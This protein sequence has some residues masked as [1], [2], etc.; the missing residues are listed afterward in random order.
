MALSP[1]QLE[2]FN[3][4]GFVKIPNAIPPALLKKLQ[5]LFEQ[6]MN[7]WEE[8]TTSRIERNGKAYITNLELLCKKGNLAA[9]ELLG[10]PFLLEM[11]EQICGTDFFMI[12]EF[13]VIKQAGDELHVYWHQDMLHEGKGRC[14][15]IGFYLDP[16]EAGDG[17]LQVVPG[18]HRAGKPICE[19]KE[20]PAIELPMMAGDILIH[21]MMLAHSSAPMRRNALRR[22]LYFEFLS[23]QH[24]LKENIYT[25]ELVK[26]RTHL[27]H[28][29]LH[30]YQQVHSNEGPAQH[31]FAWKNEWA[32]TFA[33][34]NDLPA[35]LTKIYSTPIGARPSTY[36]FEH[37]SNTTSNIYYPPV[38]PDQLLQEIIHTWQASALA[39][40]AYL[41]G[42]KTFRYAQRLKKHNT[43]IS[44]LLLQAKGQLPE[45]LQQ[46]ADAL[47]HHYSVWTQ[48]WEQLAAERNPSPEDE[49]VFANEVTFPRQAAKNIEAEYE[50]L[51]RN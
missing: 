4:D 2:G 35:L 19:L 30:H 38:E 7:R 12:Q 1:V 34:V 24:V 48:K 20:G 41:S 26:N 23:R 11:A 51:S 44:D 40:Q 9:L 49:F 39:Y 31:P 6:E 25:D 22:V 50:R 21:D 33:P 37:E 17:A 32:A 45:T 8:D 10:S 28:A 27:I 16:V 36:C 15:T 43:R 46:D 13:A 42:G 29:A 18:S 47:L 5:S 3:Q 14:F